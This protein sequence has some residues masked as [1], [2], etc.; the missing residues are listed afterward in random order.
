MIQVNT[1]PAC[2]MATNLRDAKIRIMNK[3]DS[4]LEHFLKVVF[5]PQD[6]NQNKWRNEIATRLVE[7]SRLKS[8]STNKKFD[9]SVYA[10]LFT[11]LCSSQEELEE[12][13]EAF[14]REFNIDNLPRVDLSSIDFSACYQ[15]FQSLQKKAL[16]ILVQQRIADREEFRAIIDKE[17]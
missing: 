8:S 9:R 2:E 4:L 12:Q 6:I 7:C 10:L 3:S 1:Q 16:E 13:A 17:I 5:Y 14:S 11:T 15:K